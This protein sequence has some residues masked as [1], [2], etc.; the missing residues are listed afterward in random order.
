MMN[1]PHITAGCCST[2]QR[3][4][5]FIAGSMGIL[6]IVRILAFDLTIVRI[7]MVEFP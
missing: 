7:Y 3:Y 5:G 1:D 2:G 4:G 6:V